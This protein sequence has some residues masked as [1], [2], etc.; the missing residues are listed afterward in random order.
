[1]IERETSEPGTWRISL[2]SVRAL[3]IFRQ[4]PGFLASEFLPTFLRAS[5]FPA[6]SLNSVIKVSPFEASKIGVHQ[7]Q[8]AVSFASS[9]L[10]P[11]NAG[12]ETATVGLT[13]EERVH[14]VIPWL[15]NPG[16]KSLW[17]HETILSSLHIMPRVARCV[18][19]GG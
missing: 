11:A 12:H 3:K 10:Q 2:L 8:S 4:L 17:F 5:S 16:L 14:T 9:V 15:K 7:R 6:Q 19:R 18:R 13:T 1:M